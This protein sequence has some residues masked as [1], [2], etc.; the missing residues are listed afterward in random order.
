MTINCEHESSKQSTYRLFQTRE[1][2]H[3]S[4]FCMEQKFMSKDRGYSHLFLHQRII[5]FFV[6]SYFFMNILFRHIRSIFSWNTV[7]PTCSQYI[8]RYHQKRTTDWGAKKMQVGLEDVAYETPSS[9]S[10]WLRNCK[11]WIFG[12]SCLTKCNQS[13]SNFYLFIFLQNLLYPDFNSGNHMESYAN[14]SKS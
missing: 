14:Y 13:S 5:M 2:F 9:F 1:R 12:S 10:R 7:T 3:C 4:I 8:L 11:K 6:F